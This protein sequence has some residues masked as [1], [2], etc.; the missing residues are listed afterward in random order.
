MRPY[1]VFYGSVLSLVA[2][3]AVGSFFSLPGDFLLLGAALLCGVAA[4]F[5]KKEVVVLSCLVLIFAGGAL[6]VSHKLSDFGER[7]FAGRTVTGDVRIVEDPEPKD[8][9]QKAV[10]RFLSCETENC[11]ENYILWQAPLAYELEAGQVWSFDCVLEAPENFDPEFDYA[12]FLAKDGIAYVCKDPSRADRTTGDAV[13]RIYAMLYRPKHLFEAALSRALSEPEAGLAKGL[14]LGGSDY[15]PE[16]L[17]EAFRRVGLTHVVAVS[18]YNITLITQ[19]FLILGI[20]A[21]LWRKH[22]VLSAVLGI[23]FFILMI[24]A[25]ASAV[26][27]GMMA[28]AVFAAVQSGRLTRPT[29]ILFLAGAVMLLINPLLLRYDIGFQL[30]FVATAGIVVASSW[31]ATFVHLDFVGKGWLELIWITFCVELFVV[32]LIMYHFHMFSPLM[33]LANVIV[34]PIVPF[35]MGLSFVAASAFLLWPG[36]HVFLAWVATVPL[37]AMTFFAEF[38]GRLEWA[39]LSATRFGEVS[40]FAWYGALFFVIVIIERYRQRMHYEQALSFRESQ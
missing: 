18:G 39:S 1:R 23:S 22:A 25:P 3:I 38:F 17:E 13:G 2:G 36:L 32:P 37:L 27:A 5:P 35:A 20:V 29:Y 16:F 31:W 24:G 11:P 8:F 14:L 26:R 10:I 6:W 19:G 12:M 4:C 21:G 40:L 7:P 28:G 15:L 34:L 9:Y 33:L 30:S